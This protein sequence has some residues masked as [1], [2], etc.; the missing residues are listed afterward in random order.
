MVDQ[1]EICRAV[2]LF[3]SEHHEDLELD[4]AALKRLLM[5][6]RVKDK[7]VVVISVAGAFRK[8]KSFLLNFFIRCLLN[9]CTSNWLF[10]SDGKLDGF[11]WRGGWERETVGIKLWNEIFLVPTPEGQ[12]VA[13]VLMDTQGT[14]D[15]N[16]TMKESATIFS[17]ST[18]LSSVQIYNLSQRIAQ[19][20]LQHLQF[21]CEYGKLV[22]KE[23]TDAPFQKLVFLIRDWS[24]SHQLSFGEEGG[25]E[26]LHQCLKVSEDTPEELRKLREGVKSSFEE[27][28]CFLMPHPG[29]KVAEDPN[30]NGCLSDAEPNFTQH[31]GEF[32][33]SIAHPEN[34]HP[35]RI[36]GANITCKQLCVLIQVYGEA[37]KKSD[38]PTPQSALEA[39][40]KA[41]N[42]AALA[43]AGAFYVRGMRE[44]LFGGKWLS[45]E[46]LSRCLGE[47]REEALNKFDS[48]LKMGGEDLKQQYRMTLIKTIEQY[49]GAF[50]EANT[51][52]REKFEQIERERRTEREEFER[53]IKE[54]RA[55]LEESHKRYI[56]EFEALVASEKER[57]REKV[58]NE[59]LIKKITEEREALEKRLAEEMAAFKE[60]QEKKEEQISLYHE[61][62][63]WEMAEEKKF[64]IFSY[65]REFLTSLP[66]L[67]R[68]LKD[69]L[70][71]GLCLL[72]DW[73]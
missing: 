26:Y 8:G 15:G 47:R 28:I 34:L 27:I 18:M 33:S 45:E 72:E 17:L 35:K 32:V 64:N 57:E 52:N 5:D 60:A 3:K 43:E 39:T 71:F 62:S 14:F 9:Q 70:D 10:K 21:F 24:Y 67:S 73:I 53:M 41:M 65:L 37:F 30:F 49:S 13:V 58:A 40:A 59:E 20:D 6:D 36:R 22:Q 12:E 61:S 69:G 66:F 11:A 29:T 2:P 56:E 46:E 48:A 31:L 42:A 19:D 51:V 63:G 16:S 7:P 4:V 1:A 25:R 44:V 38:I 50:V 23:V 54:Q 55:A 68:Q